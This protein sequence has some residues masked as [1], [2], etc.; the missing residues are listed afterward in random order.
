VL[1]TCGQ[2]HPGSDNSINIA[3]YCNKQYDS[4]VQ[5]V[6]KDAITD[7]AKANTEWGGIDKQATDAAAWATL[8]TPKQLDFV[9]KRLGGFTYSDQFHMLFDKAWV[10]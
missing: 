10:Q 6:L 3:G 5:A 8:F 9:S 7:P 1:L 2:I 4:N